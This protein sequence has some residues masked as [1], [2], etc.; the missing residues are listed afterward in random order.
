MNP[1]IIIQARTDSSRFPKKVLQLIE[2]KP[3]LWHVI[4]RCKKINLPIIVATT[5]RSIDDPIVRIAKDCEVDYFRGSIDDVLDRYYQ[6]AKKFNLDIIIR[7]TADCPLIDP[8]QSKKVLTLLK[9]GK[10]DYVGLD[11]KKIP[12]GLDTEGF[13]IDALEKAWENS[14]LK[15]QREHVTP[16]LKDP[17]NGFRTLIIESNDDLSKNRWTVDH[18]DDLTFVREVYKELYHGNIFYME[19]VLNL[20]NKK[21]H[22]KKINQSHKRNE[23]YEKSLKEDKIFKN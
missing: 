10:A 16:Y 23:G 3:I 22:L 18:P 21:P 14:V 7:I 1:G 6:A 19:D 17:V 12:D 5:N 20:L 11:G 8:K 13:T 2:T 15:S 4:E 9:E